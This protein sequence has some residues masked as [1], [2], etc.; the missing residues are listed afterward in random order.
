MRASMMSLLTA[1]KSVRDDTAD[2]DHVHVASTDVPT[3]L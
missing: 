3:S 2:G 1:S